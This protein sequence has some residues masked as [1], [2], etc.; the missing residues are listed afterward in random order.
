MKRFIKNKNQEKTLK[1]DKQGRSIE[2]YI[3]S[4]SSSK[5]YDVAQV[6]PLDFAPNLSSR[7]NNEIFLKREDLQSVF[8]FKLRGA[9]NKVALMNADIRSAGIIAA[10]AGNHA[11]GV[12][13]A[14][15][16]L[17][18]S[19]KIIM[20]TTT[21][22][23]KIDSVSRLG[24]QIVLHGDT[25]D[26]AYEYAL[27]LA[28]QEGKS[29]IHPYDDPEVISGQGTIAVEILKQ[30][31][32]SPHAV[33]IPVGGGGLI[34][35]MAT[36]IK[37]VSPSTK[38]IGVEPEDAPTLAIALQN[39]KRVLLEEVG[40]FADGVAVRK[41][42]KE[43]FRLARHFVDEVVLVSIDEIC[44]AVK[45]IFNDTRTLEEPAG[46]LSVAGMKKYIEEYQISGK[47]IIGINSGANVNFDRLR[48]VAERA[49]LGEGHE[50]LFGVTI[51]ER[52]GSFREFCESIG[53]RDISEFN[54]RYQDDKNA[55]VFVGIKFEDAAN[56]K[57][58]L[59]K[60]L[61][62]KGYQIIDL[63]DNEM[64]KLHLRHMVG[65]H[66]SEDLNEVLY[67][68]EF[69]E[70]PGAL[71]RFLNKIGKAWN[72][73]LF[74]YRNHGSAYGR[75]LVGI[76]VPEEDAVKFNSF[77]KSLGYSYHQETQN[78]AYRLFL[79]NPVK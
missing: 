62:K 20:P 77:L 2:D 48:H 44:A 45:D 70:R 56:E 59:T 53:K 36:Y 31:Q 55:N 39:N 49:E 69:P 52:P 15:K 73:S 26:D 8:S 18:V 47:V 41:I 13:F 40:I 38:I 1:V 37:H 63:S 29:F 65:G 11:Q 24:A 27:V 12:A 17:G 22:K 34:A 60:E 28:E 35:G 4:I 14:A 10:S 9:Y 58:K 42:G 68:F 72:I 64:A 32:G 79:N 19:S 16:H 6:S 66:S 21:P 67:R 33:F 50:T 57:S 74:H 25:Y 43:T 7:L 30:C 78:K 3:E 46:A 75:V 54:Y 5:V 76:Q 61:E 71:L 23:I 51:P